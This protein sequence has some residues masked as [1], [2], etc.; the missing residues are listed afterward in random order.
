MAKKTQ[1][2][3]KLS[4]EHKGNRAFVRLGEKIEV[5]EPL[6]VL[7]SKDKRFMTIGNSKGAIVVAISGEGDLYAFH[8]DP[9]RERSQETVKAL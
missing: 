5:T 1:A 8:G 7:R 4:K 6:V 9:V 3:E 2:A